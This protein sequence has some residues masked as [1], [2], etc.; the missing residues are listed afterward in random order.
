MR[1][2]VFG[3]G[4]PNANDPNTDYRFP[5]TA[6]PGSRF[7][8]GFGDMT[9]GLSWSPIDEDKD[10]SFPTLTLRADVQTPTGAVRDPKDQRAVLGSEGTG[11][12]G[13]SAV[14]FDVSAAMSMRMG[15]DAPY[16]DPYILVGAR[17][18][19]AV[20]ELRDQGY[21]PPWSARMRVGTAV[22]IA[23]DG[24]NEKYSVDLS[25]GL[26]FITRGRTY[27][28][29]SDYLPD[30]NQ[31]NVSGEVAYTDYSLPANY[32]SQVVGA[33]CGIVPGVPCGELNQVDEHLAVSAALAVI[34]QP[35]KWIRFRVGVD[36]IYT[37]SHILTGEP[38]GE[39]R[40]PAGAGNA[41]VGRVNSENAAGE[42][43]RSPYHDPR[44]DAV[45]RRFRAE[46][47]LSLRPFIT[48]YVTF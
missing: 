16:L 18:P 12:V 21:E 3:A 14:T 13:R 19:V 23:E 29:L 37:T 46:Q 26:R 7:R 8:A 31:T 48:A 24:R 36:A 40:D 42:D 32:A 6:V 39:D 38:V 2:T 17:L 43:E 20:G 30:F 28:E 45:G 47:I 15:A 33:Q 35:S 25:L 22:V 1:S 4:S 27:S 11:N 41:F 10:P 34:I 9:F 5:I 44:Y